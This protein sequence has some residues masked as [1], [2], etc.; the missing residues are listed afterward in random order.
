MRTAEVEVPALTPLAP[1]APAGD[2]KRQRSDSN[3]VIVF[4]DATPT[5]DKRRRSLDRINTC[6]AK[7]RRRGTD[8]EGQVDSESS[9]LSTPDADATNTTVF[10]SR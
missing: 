9:T 8:D 10:S 2:S 3:I 1:H 4:T 6:D 5:V 7:R